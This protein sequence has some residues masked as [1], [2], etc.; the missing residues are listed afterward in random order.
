MGKKV[1]ILYFNF[2]V[3]V[4]NILGKYLLFKYSWEKVFFFLLVMCEF[5]VFCFLK[6]RVFVVRLLCYDMLVLFFYYI[7]IFRRI[8]KRV[9]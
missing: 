8:Y 6:F 3:K 5:K 4:V 1:G 9:K 2:K 7:L